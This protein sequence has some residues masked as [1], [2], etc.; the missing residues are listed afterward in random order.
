MK[1]NIY[2]EKQQWGKEFKVMYL[3]WIVENNFIYLFDNVIGKE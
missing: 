3:D 2:L 1:K